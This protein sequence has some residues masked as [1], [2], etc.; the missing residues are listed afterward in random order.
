VGASAIFGSLFTSRALKKLKSIGNAEDP[1][2]LESLL[3]RI[4]LGIF[5]DL[6]LV[7]GVVFVM[8]TKPT[9]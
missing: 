2:E 1:P 6:V 3:V 4:Q 8:V 9:I 5:L 7:V